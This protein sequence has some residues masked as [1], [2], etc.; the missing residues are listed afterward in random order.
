MEEAFLG[1]FDVT[2]LEELYGPGYEDFFDQSAKQS[3][4]YNKE[5]KIFATY[6]SLSFINAATAYAKEHNLAGI[7]YWE[8]GHDMDGRIL[9]MIDEGMRGF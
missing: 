5:K 6:P 3:Y 4:R 2:Q 9:K 1:N 7:M 8:Y